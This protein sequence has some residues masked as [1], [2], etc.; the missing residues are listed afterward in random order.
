MPLKVFRGS[1]RRG[2]Y[3]CLGKPFQSSFAARG[4]LKNLGCHTLSIYV[5]GKLP[6]EA[7]TRSG[8]GHFHIRDGAFV[9][10]IR[11]HGHMSS[12]CGE[13]MV[14]SEHLHRLCDSRHPV[15]KISP[16]T[17]QRPALVGPLAVALSAIGQAVHV[18]AC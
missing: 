5:V 4:A 3:S 2:C 16:G 11:Y 1:N 9:E 10:L 8:K 12:S 13:A 15:Q 7:I 14:D 18:T 17:L 6:R